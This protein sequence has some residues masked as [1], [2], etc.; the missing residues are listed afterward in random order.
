V[1]AL[2]LSVHGAITCSPGNPVLSEDEREL[3]T[4][5]W[6]GPNTGMTVEDS[7]A[8][9]HVG[10]TFGNFRLPIVTDAHGAFAVDGE[11]LLR[12]YPVAQGPTLPARF[13]GRIR[14]GVLTLVVVVNDTT[15]HN[16]ETL[17]PVVL[18]FGRPP[19]LGPCPI[20]RSMKDGVVRMK[21]VSGM[22]IARVSRRRGD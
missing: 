22:G 7:V 5:S 20:C 8:H 10:C 21:K 14:S 15:T 17:G 3:A 19:Q 1:L 18:T 16:T 13:T 2:V 4:G 9:V 12:A 11:Y 6:G